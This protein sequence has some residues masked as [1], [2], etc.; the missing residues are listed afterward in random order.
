LATLLAVSKINDLTYFFF[1]TIV[2]ILSPSTTVNTIQ[3]A[4]QTKKF[5][6]ARKENHCHKRRFGSEVRYKDLYL[7]RC[8]NCTYEPYRL[9]VRATI[10]SVSSPSPS[11]ASPPNLILL[12]LTKSENPKLSVVSTTG[13]VISASKSGVGKARAG[14]RK[15]GG[16]YLLYPNEW[17]LE[18]V[19][20]AQ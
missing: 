5:A 10:H 6:R 2:A 15:P 18:S 17:P 16:I 3:R 20:R 7:F 13:R 8:P 19:R 11:R 1:F 14:G 4:L 12:K 9:K